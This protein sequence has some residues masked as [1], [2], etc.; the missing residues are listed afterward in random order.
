MKMDW[1]A[2]AVA[3]MVF[4]SISNVF[5]KLVVANP[6]FAKLDF[7]AFLIPIALAAAGV[8]LFLFLFSQ[9][10]G[11][12]LFYYAIGIAVFALLGFVA[13]VLALQKGKVALVT[14]V[15]SLSTVLVAFISIAFLG[16]KFTAKEISAMLLAILSLVM[17]IS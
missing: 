17:L 15:L 5:L 7:N 6:A 11:G 4:L 3:G 10:A 1:L 14:A 16:E 9:K 13:M 12:Q 2:F 8:L